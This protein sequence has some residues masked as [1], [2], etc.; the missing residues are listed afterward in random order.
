MSDTATTEAATDAKQARRDLTRGPVDRHLF[1]LTVPM[2][3]GIVAVMSISLADAYFLGQL[4]TKELAAISF[5]F[6]VVFTFSTLAIG[7]GAGAT[8]VV[9]RAIGENDRNQVRRLSTDSFILAVIIVAVSCVAGWLTIGPLFHLLGAEGEVFDLVERY[10]RIWYLG[11]PFLVVPMVANNLIRAT[12]DAFVPSVIMTVAAVINV[13]L[14]PVFIFG[15][16][17]FPA[18]GVEGA[19]WASLTARAIS[20]V[21]SLTIVIWREKLITFARA[22]LDELV[23]SWRRVL[24]VGIPAA[25]GNMM[26]PIGVAVVTGILATYGSESVAAFG[27][28]TRI[29]MLAAIPL[30]ALSASIGPIAGQNWGA[31]S[32]G[33]IRRSLRLS[34]GFAV[35]WA[36]AM[37]TGAFFAG[38]SLAMAF[39]SDPVVAEQISRYLLIISTS[40][41]GYG[42]IVVAAACCNAIG[43]PRWSLAIFGGRMAVLYVPLAWLASLYFGVTAVFWAIW[44]ANIL[45]GLFAG[46]VVFQVLKDVPDE[47]IIVSDVV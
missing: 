45:A 25:L 29:E 31:G 15:G 47:I 17:G 4:G 11:M 42:V 35:G 36:L 28:A 32:P 19:A 39:T 40:L 22:P 13:V 43:H 27:A 30:L 8:S 12:G 10:M 5:T 3:W 6:P 44:L 34:F 9:S 41:M 2:I 21:F 23:R 37:G 20:F 1:N 38:P 26:N 18:L 24:G 7:L 16:F 33:R 14:D 46:F